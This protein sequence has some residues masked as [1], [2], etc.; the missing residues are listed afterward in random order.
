VL[1]L[2]RPWTADVARVVD[3]ITGGE[4][5]DL[6]A[7]GLDHPGRIPTQHARVFF[8]GA[9]RGANLGVDRIDGYGLDP[10][11]EVARSRRRS[12]QLHVQEGFR[13]VDG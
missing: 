2:I 4:K 11:Q 8:D 5:P 7:Y 13:V 1:G 10:H 9:P 3:G 12:R 6:V